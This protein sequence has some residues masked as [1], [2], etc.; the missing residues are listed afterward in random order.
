MKRWHIIVET[1]VQGAIG[2]WAHATY[3]INADTA[4]EASDHALTAAHEDG[5]ETRFVIGV[6]E[7]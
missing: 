1:R 4:E 6:H 5:L 7:R 2:E 3:A